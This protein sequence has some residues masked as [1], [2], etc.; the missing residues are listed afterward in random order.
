MLRY[1]IHKVLDMSLYCA[2]CGSITSHSILSR[3][4]FSTRVKVQPGIPLVCTCNVCKSSFMAFTQEFYFGTSSC[5]NMEYAKVLERSRLIPRDWLYVKGE[6][7]PGRV[8]ATYQTRDSDVAVVDY[9]AGK[10]ETVSRP[11]LETFD[12]RAPLGYRLFPAQ[13]GVALLGDPVYHVIRDAFGKVVGRVT[14]GEKDKLAVLLENGTLLFITL[15][16]ENQYLPDSKLLDNLTMKI[17]GIYP[18]SISSLKLTVVNAVAYLQGKASG[19]PLKE[20]IVKLVEGI[21]ELRGCVDFIAV[22]VG[23]VVPDS[24]LERAAFCI[25]EDVTSPL[26][27][28]TVE[29]RTGIL[30]VS[31]FYSEGKDPTSVEE[32]LRR[33]E[34]LRDVVFEIEKAPPEAP[35]MR[36]LCLSVSRILKENPRMANSNLRVSVLDDSLLLEGRVNSILQKSL[37]GFVVKKET[38]QTKLINRL[39]IENV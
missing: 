15:P 11:I 6:P 3:E 31:A 29:V 37:A 18:E 10:E 16:D 27:N 8:S 36:Q 17:S 34:G 25:L 14:D 21:P 19:Y 30:Q 12:E 28:Y 33:L 20:K 24:S 22:E 38:V 23:K 7:R 13:C 26:F 2:E 4:L 1:F 32:K 9:G 5:G 35:D 39:R